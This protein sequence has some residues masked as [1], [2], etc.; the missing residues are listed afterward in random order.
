MKEDLRLA[1]RKGDW[2]AILLVA[3]IAV[4]CVVAYIPKGGNAQENVA[5]IFRDGQLLYELP[6]EKDTVVEVE[7]DYTNTV[8]ISGGRASITGSDCPGEDCVHSGWIS[9]AGRSIVCLPNRVELRISG[10]SQVDFTVR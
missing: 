1:F 5:M 10:S 2:L 8:T 9:S 6:L 3:L 7:G 4:A